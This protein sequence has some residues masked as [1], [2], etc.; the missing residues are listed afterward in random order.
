MPDDDD[1]IIIIRNDA[2]TNPGS[3]PPY[4]VGTAKA[5]ENGLET[6]DD[7]LHEVHDAISDPT[8]KAKLVSARAYG[9]TAH[10]WIHGVRTYTP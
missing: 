2:Q 9:N 3:P 8:L 1:E 5:A 6:A 10:D 7:L 4:T